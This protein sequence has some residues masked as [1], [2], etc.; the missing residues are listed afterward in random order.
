MNEA[1]ILQKGH[2][3]TWSKR[4]GTDSGLEASNEGESSTIRETRVLVWLSCFLRLFWFVLCDAWQTAIIC[5]C[6][7]FML[8]LYSYS[9]SYPLLILQLFL[10]PH[11][12]LTPLWLL[13]VVDH[14]RF[15][16]CCSV[17]FALPRPPSSLHWCLMLHGRRGSYLPLPTVCSTHATLPLLL[18]P[19]AAWKEGRV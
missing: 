1:P 13:Y 5:L 8:W 18:T 3:V 2:Q 19:N 14:V 17:L 6:Y 9:Y 16:C 12:L 7:L 11:I 10:R 15:Y 4:E